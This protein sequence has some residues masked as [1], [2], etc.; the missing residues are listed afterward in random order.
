MPVTEY[1]NNVFLDLTTE[2]NQAM[3]L[4]NFSTNLCFLLH[5]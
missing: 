3:P 2:S 4:Q 5:V 1:F